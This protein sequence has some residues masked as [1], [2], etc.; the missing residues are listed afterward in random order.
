MQRTLW[1]LSVTI[2]VLIASSV[3]F[4]QTKGMMKKR[5]LPQDYGNI[6]INSLSE[7]NGMAPVVFKHWLHRTRYTC[8]VC[9]VDF[10]FA[11]IAGKTAMKEAGNE[12]HYCSSCHNGK[13]A[14]APV[15]KNPSGEDTVNCDRC[16]SY[17]KYVKFEFDFYKFTAKFPRE[18]FGDG[19]NWE[20]AE[21]EGI[22]KL[23]D[24]VP[25]STTKKEPLEG[26]ADFTA[27]SD[28]LGLPASVFSHK[29]H[30]VGISCELCHNDIFDYEK[31]ITKYSMDDIFDGKY[32][33]RCHGKVAF[34]NDDCL[35]CH[36]ISAQAVK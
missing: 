9:H 21:N 24:E 36:R 31:G 4:A 28:A 14:F 23:Q 27:G 13:E 6:V 10:G 19:I 34:S 1:L 5:S 32:C 2:A 29:K 8:R 35:R 17:G 7:K 26:P 22:I 33:G 12:G 11:M 20:K 16:H 3:A 30:I 25:A 15:A 18:S